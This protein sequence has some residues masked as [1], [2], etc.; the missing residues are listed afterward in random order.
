MIQ[1]KSG[2]T[3]QVHYKGT[4]KDG[5]LFDS[6][7]GR[8]PLQFEVGKGM[9]IKGFDDALL[10]MSIGDKKTVDIPVEQAYG[11]ANPEM[12]MEFSKSD[13]PADMAPEAGM[14]IHLSDNMGNNFP[15]LIKEVKDETVVIDANH[16]L[17]GKDLIFEIELVAIS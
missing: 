11:Q 3:V 10:G 9:V 17:A 6:S 5:T 2:D 7:E 8:D 4:L 12:V 13:F 15:T 16:A 1:V 14:Q